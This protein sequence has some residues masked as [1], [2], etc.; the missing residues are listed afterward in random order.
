MSLCYKEFRHSVTK[1]E[2]GRNVMKTVKYLLGKLGVI[3]SVKYCQ[4]WFSPSNSRIYPS[5][6]LPS[7]FFGYD[8]LTDTRLTVRYKVV[9]LSI[10]IV[11]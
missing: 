11:G 3:F 6:L 10:P 5:C 7:W 4:F 8:N 2:G 9:L 1:K